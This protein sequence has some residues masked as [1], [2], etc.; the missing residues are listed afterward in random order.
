MKERRVTDVQIRR[1][2][3]DDSM[4]LEGYAIVFNSPATYDG[5]TE[6]IAP[7]ALDDCDMSDVVLRYNHSS[8]NYTLARTRNK[9][10][11][12]TVDEKGLFFHAELIPTTVNTDAYM[13]VKS[14]LL[15]KC[16]F[17]FADWEYD[18]D[19]KTKTTT[20]TKIGVLFDV[21]LVDFPYYPETSVEARGL[22]ATNNIR[23]EIKEQLK[24]ELLEKL[25]K[26]E[27]LKRL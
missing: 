25:K 23:Q 13:M 15:D 20:I 22:E 24:K 7:G 5:E 10:L 3:N 4:I 16:S 12:L 9:S 2:E 11:T 21:A 8:E 17:A 18:Y 19:K 26:E 14:G 6:V 1:A 27:L